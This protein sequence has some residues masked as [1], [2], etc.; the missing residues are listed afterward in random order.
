MTSFRFEEKVTRIL[1]L[2]H[3]KTEKNLIPSKTYEVFFCLDEVIFSPS[4]FLKLLSNKLSQLL[5][6]YSHVQ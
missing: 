4:H 3:V 5:D 2:I 1:D 6:N